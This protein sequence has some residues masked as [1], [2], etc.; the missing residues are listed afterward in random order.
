[1]LRI[2]RKALLVRARELN[3][4][5]LGSVLLSCL[6]FG[7]RC[8]TSLVIAG[9]LLFTALTPLA[10]QPDEEFNTTDVVQASLTTRSSSAPTAVSRA[11]NRSRG[12]VSARKRLATTL[13]CPEIRF[14]LQSDSDGMDV[15][16]YSL[17]LHQWAS[18]AQGR[19]P[20]LPFIPS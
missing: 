5:F 7:K 15:Q 20:P 9:C 18:A 4:D 19:S 6:S 17:L 8:I 14:S 13:V 12:G 1:M 3:N 16:G 10:A 2:K 11:S